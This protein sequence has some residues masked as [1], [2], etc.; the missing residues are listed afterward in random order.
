MCHS[1]RLWESAAPVNSQQLPCPGLAVQR[2]KQELGRAALAA[3]AASS[4]GRFRAGALP[5]PSPAGGK[6]HLSPRRLQGLWEGWGKEGL[7][8]CLL[9]PFPPTLLLV[10]FF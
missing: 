1:S 8:P 9:S 10:L 4:P 6:E 2:D 3:A 7:L 5:A